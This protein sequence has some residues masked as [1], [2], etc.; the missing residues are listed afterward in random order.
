MGSTNVLGR[1]EKQPSSKNA[2]I[3]T[4]RSR[5]FATDC[6]EFRLSNQGLLFN[7]SFEPNLLKKEI[8]SKENSRPQS[9]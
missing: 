6:F 9:K 2:A 8:S 1:V 7:H 3:A 4:N 5:V